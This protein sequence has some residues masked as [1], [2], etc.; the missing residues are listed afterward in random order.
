MLDTKIFVNKGIIFIKCQGLVNE[1]TIEEFDNTINYLLYNIGVKNFVIDFIDSRLDKRIIPTLNNKLIEI[2]T[3]SEK[4]VLK[5][6]N[7]NYLDLSFM[8]A[9]CY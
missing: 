1:G 5:G 8:K 9:G 7:N 4:L 3:K 6:L 2:Y